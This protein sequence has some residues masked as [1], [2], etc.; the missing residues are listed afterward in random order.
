MIDITFIIPA[1]NCGD[2]ISRAVKSIEKHSNKIDYEILIIENGST[3]N[4]NLIIEQLAKKNKRIKIFH[5]QKGVSRARNKGL[6][7]ALGKWIWFVDADDCVTTN[8]K[9]ILSHKNIVSTDLIIGEY[10]VNT[11]VVNMSND[12]KIL[13]ENK[14]EQ[15]ILNMISAPNRYMTIWNKLFRTSIIKKNQIK[16]DDSLKVAEDS[17]FLFDYLQKAKSLFLLDYVI[18]QYSTNTNSTV[19]SLQLNDIDEYTIAMQKMKSRIGNNTKLN[20]AIYKYICSNFSVAM[21]RILFANNHLSFFRKVVL[22]K[23]YGAQLVYKNSFSN[24]R[25]K[26]LKSYQLIP[27]I[28][29]KFD[30]FLLAGCM[31]QFKADLNYRRENNV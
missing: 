28:C 19:R 10:V 21:V 18:Y 7:Y 13:R 20:R 8:V 1:Y 2:S 24:L 12:I 11:S 15:Y 30:F 26:D 23:K 4:T 29:L 16:F 31:F 9:N 14:F 27:S 5:S 22:L 17:Q 25:L 6:D 3:D